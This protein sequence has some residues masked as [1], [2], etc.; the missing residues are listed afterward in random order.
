VL[1]K[2]VKPYPGGHIRRIRYLQTRSL[3][4]GVQLRYEKDLRKDRTSDD[5]L[6]KPVGH[7][8]INQNFT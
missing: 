6:L 8:R 7:E 3:A 4:H 1:I 2:R 5:V